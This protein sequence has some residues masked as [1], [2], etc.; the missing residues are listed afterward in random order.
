MA[1]R[2]VVALMFTALLYTVPM[3]ALGVVP[4]VV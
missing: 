1:C 4:L 2:V 3:V